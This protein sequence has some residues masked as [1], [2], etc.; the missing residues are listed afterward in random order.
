M[1]R[2]LAVALLIA[3]CQRSEPPAG[4]VG[5]MTRVDRAAAWLAAFP[6]ERLRFDAAIG[7]AAILARR[8][9]PTVRDATARARQRGDGDGDNPLRR[10]FDPAAQVT[11][12]A[13]R[14][15]AVPGPGAPRVNVNRVVGEALSCDVHGLR[16]EALAY[17]A[18]PMRDGGGYQST[19]AAW[20]LA[21]A[22]GRGCV[23]PAA[24]AAAAGPLIAELKLAQPAVPGAA[25][26]E[27]D[28]FAERLLML[29]LLGERDPT[30]TAWAAALG[31]AQA[32]DGGF[33][34]L[35]EGEEPYRRYHATMMAGWALSEVGGR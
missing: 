30:L 23:E 9:S 28:L 25:V 12:E 31:A 14:G 27:V 32:A 3:G 24:F 13:A 18:G 34:A 1:I 15:W 8:D 35:A 19:H 6:G 4:A 10:A 33:G 22:H 16:P 17:L 7:T 5:P 29:W 26:L 2:R 20:A 21:I 11:A